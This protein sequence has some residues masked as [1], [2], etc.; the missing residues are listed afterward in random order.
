[1]SR[2]IFLEFLFISC[3]FFLFFSSFSRAAKI[4]SI[5]SGTDTE[6]FST[7]KVQLSAIMH[8]RFVRLI[9]LSVNIQ[10]AS[11][12]LTNPMLTD[13]PKLVITA[14]S[15]VAQSLFAVAQSPGVLQFCAIKKRQATSR[16]SR[17]EGQAGR[18]TRSNPVKDVD[19]PFSFLVFLSP[20]GGTRR[21]WNFGGRMKT[22]EI[23]KKQ[24]G[25]STDTHTR[26]N[27]SVERY[28]R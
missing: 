17:R 18:E 9:S 28:P 13:T 8:L 10:F 15:S 3:F 4:P 6:T 7:W 23:K 12:F 11:S 5:H 22:R 21:D 19:D 14:R 24:V 16:A 2:E 1:M 25:R 20:Q 26:E 27:K